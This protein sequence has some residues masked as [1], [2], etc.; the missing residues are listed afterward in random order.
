M[1]GPISTSQNGRPTMLGHC[2]LT[3]LQIFIYTECFVARPSI[4]YLYIYMAHRPHGYMEGLELKGGQAQDWAGLSPHRSH[5]AL[6]NRHQ[7][8]TGDSLKVTINEILSLVHI[9]ALFSFYTI[10]YTRSEIHP[11]QTKYIQLFLLHSRPTYILSYSWSLPSS[12]SDWDSLVWERERYMLTM[13]VW[14][15]GYFATSTDWNK[16]NICFLFHPITS[17]PAYATPASYK[18]PAWWS[19]ESMRVWKRARET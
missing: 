19:V 13:Y 3:Y 2:K 15:S 1:R 11:Q 5:G 7:S 17:L 6:V 16:R 18:C 8:S 10:C 9:S 4:C 14:V 12:H